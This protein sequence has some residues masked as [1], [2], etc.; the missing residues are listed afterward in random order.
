MSGLL[1]PMSALL[2]PIVLTSSLL[3]SNK[4]NNTSIASN[5]NIVNDSNVNL[6]SRMG[7]SVGKELNLNGFN[8]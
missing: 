8:I 4:N 3:L 5:S 2:L 1:L 7:G 6:E